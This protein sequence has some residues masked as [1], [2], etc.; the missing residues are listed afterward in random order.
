MKSVRW[1][2]SDCMWWK[3]FIEQVSFELGVKTARI[4]DKDDNDEMAS[5]I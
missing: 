4:M 3:G 1:V 2:P 5:V